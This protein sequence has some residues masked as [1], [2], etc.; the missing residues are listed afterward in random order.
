MSVSFFFKKKIPG[1]LK[2]KREL[3]DRIK[4]LAFIEC[5]VIGEITIIIVSDKELLSIN[6]QYLNHNYY[7]D[8]ITFDYNQ[9]SEING[10]LFISIDRISENAAKYNSN[11][12]QEL[13]RVI[14]HGILHLCGYKDKSSTQKSTMR[15]K[16]NYYLHAPLN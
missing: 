12:R 13:Y 8:I 15:K 16:E 5:R 2:G 10:D 3:L 14:I 4:L 7:T 6:Q 11:S 9:G 1:G